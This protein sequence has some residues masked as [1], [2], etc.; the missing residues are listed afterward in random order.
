MSLSLELSKKLK[1]D[2]L[3]NTMITELEDEL[4]DLKTILNKI[5]EL[6]LLREQEINEIKNEAKR[7]LNMLDNDINDILE[8]LD[9]NVTTLK[10]RCRFCEKEKRKERKRLKEEV[11]NNKDD[12]L[13]LLLVCKTK[14]SKLLTDLEYEKHN[15]LHD[16]TILESRLIKLGINT[17]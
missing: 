13:D 16:I 1:V 12:V 4:K 8:K 15:A 17:N 5:K 10:V 11:K 14:I 2:K 9:V 7:K 3:G 6:E